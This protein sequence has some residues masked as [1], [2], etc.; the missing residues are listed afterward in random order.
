M[1]DEEFLAE[2]QRLWPKL[3][4]VGKTGRV[5]LKGEALSFLRGHTYQNDLERCR[6]CGEY[7]FYTARFDGDPLAYDMAHIKS[8]GAGGSDLPSNVKALCHRDHMASH[9]GKRIA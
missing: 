4:K 6:H 1:T 7:I 8:R 9:S 5:R 2:A 3:V